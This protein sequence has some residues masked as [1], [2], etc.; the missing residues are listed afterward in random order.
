VSFFI[1]TEEELERQKKAMMDQLLER[2]NVP[3]WLGM[4]MPWRRGGDRI[5][6]E[7][8]SLRGSEPNQAEHI[9]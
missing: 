9:C 3:E 5:D 4:M 1:V 6:R 2:A 8:G 7:A